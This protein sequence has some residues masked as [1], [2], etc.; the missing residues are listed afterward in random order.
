MTDTRGYYQGLANRIR[1]DMDSRSPRLRL[2]AL[3]YLV[4]AGITPDSVGS[5]QDWLDLLESTVKYIGED[6]ESYVESVETFKLPEPDDDKDE[7]D[8]N[9][10]S[11]I[12]EHESPYL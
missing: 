4:E 8:K 10:Y 11:I 3:A 12:S 2:S 6:F 1:I 5:V 7:K 9:G